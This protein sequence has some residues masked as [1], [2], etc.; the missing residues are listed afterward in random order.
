MDDSAAAGKPGK[1]TP[2]KLASRFRN[3]NISFIV[4]ILVIMAA[5]SA[6]M[7]YTAADRA[8]MDY[9]RFFS[10]ETVDILNT[11]LNKEIFLIRHAAGADEITAWFADEGNPDKKRAAYQK[12]TH[13]ADMLQI[14]GMY[15]VIHNSLNEYSVDNGAPFEDFAP[16]NVI[17]PDKLYDRWFFDAVNSEYDFTLNMDIDKVTDT[18][19]LWI[20]YKVVSDG[21]TVGIICSALQ[22]D[23]IFEQLFGGH[24]SRS[25]TAFIID[26]GGTIQMSSHLPEPFL[27]TAD[28]TVD[29]AEEKRH[30]L[31][32]KSD[33]SFASAINAYLENLAA[34]CGGRV[35][36]DVVKLGSGNGAFRYMS[37]APV[38]NTSWS[39]VTFYS[40]GALFNIMSFM[41]PIIAV[42]L[43]FMLYAAASSALTQRLVFGPL[44]RLTRSM[45]ESGHNS[46]CIYGLRR[47]DEIGE[48]ARE[49]KDSW[50]RLGE[51]T[52]RLMSLADERGKQAQIL[53]A[54]NTMAATL[55]S[56]ENEAVFEASL[57][58]GLKIL[59]DCMDVDRVSIWRN[60]MR[61][62]VLH[63]I[64]THEWTNGA[65]AAAGSAIGAGAAFMYETNAPLW[66][67][68]FLRDE[69]V[70][71]PVSKMPEGAEKERAELNGAISVL[72]VPIHLHGQFW[73]FVSFDNCRAEH[74]LPQED[75]DILR[76]GS[77]IIASAIN[78]NI[79]TA[80][81][82]KTHEY[83]GMMLNAMPL[84]C[85]LWEDAS[86]IF[87]CNETV[88]EL[89][90]LGSK[91]EYARRFSSLLPEYQPDGTLTADK[92]ERSIREAMENG[93][94]VLEFMHLLPN[95]APLP[96]E[97]TVSRVT[98]GDDAFIATYA[99]DLREHKQM[100]AE[101]ERCDGLLQAI[102]RSAALLLDTKESE[103][104]DNLYRSMEM[105]AVA[106]GVDRGYIWKNHVYEGELY[107]SQIYEWYDSS[108]LK[109]G[110][111]FTQNINYRG[112]MP[113][114]EE[115]LSNGRC[116]NGMARDMAPPTREFLSGTQVLSVFAAPIFMKEKFWGFAGFDDCHTERTFSEREA[117][118]LRSGCLLIGNAFLRHDMTRSMH[119]TSLKLEDR[120][121]VLEMQTA[122][123]TTLFDSIPAHIFAKDLN[124]DYTECNRSMLE[125][126]GLNKEDV[127]GKD[128]VN[129]IKVPA[130][131]AEKFR[132][133]DRRVIGEGRIIVVEDPV[134]GVLGEHFIYEIIKAPL[135]LSGSVIGVLGISFDITERK[136]AERKLELQTATLT[137]LFDSIP[138]IIVAKD[139]DLRY[140]HYNKAFSRHFGGNG[141]FM[142]KTDA[143]GLGLPAETVD[144]LNEIDRLVI[145]ER[146]AHAE[147]G[148]LP[149]A[150]GSVPY[151]ETIKTPLIVNDKV[152]GVL[153]IARDITKRKEMEAAVVAASRSKS[154]FLANMSHE[155]RTPMNSIVGFS[156]LALDNGNPPNTQDYLTKIKD[157]SQWLL[158]IINDILDI[159]KIESGKLEL[160]NI[161]FDMSE[162]FASCRTVIMPKTIEKGLALHF[163]AEPSV[164][165]V[166][167]GDPTRLRQVLVNLLSNAVKFTGSG[168]IKMQASV[169]EIK[170]DSVTM[171]FEVKDSGIGITEEQM[172][173]I[174]DPFTQA[175]TGTTRKYGG[176]GLGLA[177]TKNII[178]VMGGKLY[179]DSIPGV[180][181]KFS[182]E[183]TFDAAD[184]GGG[185]VP[186]EKILFDDLEKPTFEGDV[187]LCEDNGMNQQV[188]TE[189]LARV[190]L[191]TTVAANGKIGVEMVKNRA[192]KG[193][194]Q[195]DL[196]FMDIHMPVMDGLEASAKI[197]EFDPGIP[198]VA[199][200]ANIMT[201]D[202]ELY[203][204]LGMTDCVGKP[205]TSQELWRCLMKYFKPVIW[206]KEDTARRERADD[207]LRQRLINN[208]VESN[209]NKCGEI[210]EALNAGDITLAHRLAH[211]LKN[212]AGQLKKA[213]L[214]QAAEEVESHLADG[215]NLAAP[216]HIKALETELN[217]VLA[218]LTPL[219]REPVLPASPVKPLDETALRELLDK[220]EPLL[221]NCDVECLA[222]AGSL[223]AVPG[224]GELTRH[225]ENMDFVHAMNA[226]NELRNIY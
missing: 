195:F 173:R 90:G 169:K 141:D 53:H 123:L 122:T 45:S 74:A 128:D 61:D 181:S 35:E 21:N 131:V 84:A 184:S 151:F 143:D 104:E 66:L 32:L 191:K 157:N 204:S 180:G 153:G 22:F 88:V 219:A 85:T 16:F 69:C 38:P 134:P 114:W 217:A 166:L 138:D 145:S 52:V 70:N 182:F 149:A 87:D 75:I 140:T 207:E 142:G 94:C 20:N 65:G 107:S 55:L 189:H 171:Y 213:R 216:A 89:F 124:L 62:G 155:I 186:V 95:G 211:S 118:I 13:Y 159:S 121:R 221:V 222:F 24:D 218:E 170:T 51:N 176:T 119:E 43:A 152:I 115:A 117:S 209:K 79:Q 200:T 54:V 47:D 163:Y 202:R 33:P 15:F 174:F 139:M 97:V 99:R 31:E 50:D 72:A 106:V 220:L 120:T 190:G 1:G 133:I 23:D 34:Y 111:A 194:K 185:D 78:R 82:R 206:Q 39:A 198:V 187:L 36:P 193:E 108:A 64:L 137:T 56:A 116:V 158:Q 156:E 11:H 92:M 103:F 214:R 26:S 12:M 68:C 25:V 58:K 164:G 188:I 147:D 59:A 129:G 42:I 9:V 7:S 86:T 96:V 29:D 150:D 2:N 100:M 178:E 212:N 192:V 125:H 37:I 201:N 81:L 19:R 4:I 91:S 46:D 40:S 109:Q 165:K 175:E 167:Y 205:F 223:R 132:A 48:L 199:M 160:E 44:G 77:L 101:I 172:T 73:G 41:P 179:V 5:A 49:T 57:P 113:D 136:E 208:F 28:I 210:A 183:I 215:M 10:M 112:T 93:R 196:V 135:I 102:D 197:N 226:F 83:A 161:P 148:F 127:I 14:K 146:R 17:D 63:H 225:I 144:R 30:I 203:Q 177:I 224:S 110:D 168:L 130:E 154:V 105:M 60:E 6:F 76:S 8:S 98:R 27:P 67:E 3:I 71:S 80:E 126:F 18:A 162:M